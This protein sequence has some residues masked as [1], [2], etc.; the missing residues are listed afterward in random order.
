MPEEPLR[1]AQFDHVSDGGDLVFV[2]DHRHFAV[3]V[4]DSLERGILEAKQIRAEEEGYPSPQASSALPISRIQSF[5][6]AGADPEAVARQ[7]NIAQ[8]LVRRF[9]MPVE[10]E[11][12]YAI[13]Q[14]LTVAVPP[15]SKAKSYG[16]LIEM[17]LRN[18]RIPMASITWSATRRGHEPWRI[19][20]QFQSA[21]RIITADWNWNIRDNSVSPVNR[22]AKRLIGLPDKALPTEKSS[23]DQALDGRGPLPFSWMEHDEDAISEDETGSGTDETASGTDAQP[24]ASEITNGSHQGIARASALRK[25]SDKGNAADGD[26]LRG[27]DYNHASSADSGL[28]D[29]GLVDSQGIDLQFAPQNTDIPDVSSHM[30]YVEGDAAS[31]KDATD[32]ALEGKDRR[33][34]GREPRA[35]RYSSWMYKSSQ[36]KAGRQSTKDAGDLRHGSSGKG[37]GSVPVSAQPADRTDG[38]AASEEPSNSNPQRSDS[39]ATGTSSA[40]STAHGQETSKKKSGRSA[41]PSWDEI[42]FGD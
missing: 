29:S 20:A 25:P 3:R 35:N 6:R 18:A 5:I 19:R 8:A 33:S 22:Q 38:R 24:Q 15:N 16:D 40:N 9:S 39:H 34:S 11:K 17:T 37:S 30:A 41:V 42:L 7:F 2:F 21:G 13:D 23:L 27:S 12:K 32:E 14:F 26:N 1:I 31:P 4:D 36:D 10:T 28:V